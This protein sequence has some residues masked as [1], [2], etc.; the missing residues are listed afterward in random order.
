MRA[1]V[2]EEGFRLVGYR[3]SLKLKLHGQVVQIRGGSVALHAPAAYCEPGDYL[4]CAVQLEYQPRKQDLRHEQDRRHGHRPV[5]IREE[6]GHEKSHRRGGYRGQERGYQQ[7]QQWVHYQPLLGHADDHAEYADDE[8]ALYHAEH[9]E[10]DYFRHYVR[11][12]G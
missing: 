12:Q 7:L 3:Q 1:G 9:S 5:R 8:H 10:H 4:R 6:G 11:R 2:I